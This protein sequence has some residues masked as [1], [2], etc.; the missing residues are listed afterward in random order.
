MDDFRV[1]IAMAVAYIV[2]IKVGMTV[3]KG[4]VRAFG[5]YV[6]SRV[7]ALHALNT[8]ATCRQKDNRQQM[9]P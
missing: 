6:C 9:T 3:M 1:S 4:T 5:R 8:L 2:L 7:R